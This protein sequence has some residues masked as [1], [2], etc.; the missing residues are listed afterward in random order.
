MIKSSIKSHI[1]C[2]IHY[3]GSTE[4]RLHYLFT[5][6]NIME[7]AERSVLPMLSG[8]SPLHSSYRHEDPT[9][10]KSDFMALLEYLGQIDNVPKVNCMKIARQVA[11]T[12]TFKQLYNVFE[13]CSLTNSRHLAK[14]QFIEWIHRYPSTMNVSLY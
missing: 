8:Q 1:K 5:M 14:S 13:E 4:D 3:R 7:G 10:W 2:T 6:F 12:C 9:I 11:N